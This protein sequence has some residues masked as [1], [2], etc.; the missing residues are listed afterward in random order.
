[1]T[2]PGA[3]VLMVNSPT[4]LPSVAIRACPAE[5]VNM[6]LRPDGPTMTP[7]RRGNSAAAA[8]VTCAA[9]D[10]GGG[11]RLGL[12]SGLSKVA[13]AASASWPGASPAGTGPSPALARTD[14]VA[15]AGV[16]APGSGPGAGAMISHARSPAR[17]ITGKA[18]ASIRLTAGLA[19]F[20]PGSRALPRPPSG[21]TR[22][23]ARTPSGRHRRRRPGRGCRRTA[24]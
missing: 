2:W 17:M 21:P 11:R 22:C 23:A 20:E 13:R 19:S 4:G 24:P 1:M 7:L 10:G 3:I 8:A 14:A 12:N 6:A 18:S 16:P 5:S 15:G 9:A